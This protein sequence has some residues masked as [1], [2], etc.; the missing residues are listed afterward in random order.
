MAAAQATAEDESSPGRRHERAF[1][2]SAGYAHIRA[3]LLPARSRQMTSAPGRASSQARRDSRKLPPGK[4]ID[5]STSLDTN[6]HRAPP[7]CHPRAIGHLIQ[8]N[9]PD[10][11]GHI[12]VL[13]RGVQRVFAQWE[14]FDGPAS[15]G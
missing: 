14:L 2:P 10:K 12:L 3:E 5:S 6:Q 1:T 9:S 8:P 11:L 4:H 13:Q 7:D 15:R